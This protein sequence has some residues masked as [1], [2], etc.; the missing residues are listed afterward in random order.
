MEEDP[1][2]I[3]ELV[4]DVIGVLFCVTTRFEFETKTTSYIPFWK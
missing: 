3:E 4:Y 2:N 1:A